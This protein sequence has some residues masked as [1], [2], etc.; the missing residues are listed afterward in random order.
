MVVEPLMPCRISAGLYTN[1]VPS[2]MSRNTA[3]T[4]NTFDATPP[5]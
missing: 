4:S 2:M 5:R 1:T 3:N